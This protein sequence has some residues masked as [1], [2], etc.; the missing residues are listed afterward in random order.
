VP[1]K[2]I[3]EAHGSFAGQHCIEC[4][5]DFPDDEMQRMI[6]TQEIPRCRRERCR[7]LVKPDIVFFG[8]ALPPAFHKSIPHL[9]SADLLIVMG[10]SLTVHPFASLTELVP[11][12][13]PRL[14]L[15]LDHVGGWG[16]RVNDVAC[17]RKCDDAVRLLCKGLGW[18]E[19]LDVLWKGM[20]GS[21]EKPAPDVTEASE[22]KQKDKVAAMTEEEALQGEVD[23]LT[24]EIEK[25]LK[26]TAE[27]E[28]HVRGELN[29]KAEASGVGVPSKDETTSVVAESDVPIEAS[30][31]DEKNKGIHAEEESKPTIQVEPKNNEISTVSSIST[32]EPGKL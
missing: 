28:E 31:E 25:G 27:H 22:G 6:E 10:T 26:V 24:K 8:E 18:E 4:K 15:N 21:V 23:K 3:V 11:E 1:A 2:K 20:S 30:P 29:V 12:D 13:C 9:R 32:S 14:L 16:S 17:L 7:G 5:G 19:E